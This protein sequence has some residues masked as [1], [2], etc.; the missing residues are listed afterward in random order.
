MSSH[1]LGK[2]RQA[3]LLDGEPLEDV[4]IFQYVG[5]IFVGSGT[6]RI[7]SRINLARSTFSHL[8]SCLWRR[9]EISA[10]KGQGLP[11]S[12]AFDSA[13]WLRAVA[14]TSRRRHDVGSL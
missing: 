3:V 14:S 11:D 2:Q 7:I 4:D 10:Y 5:G 13:L 6:E 12:G 9:R 8:Q 1:I